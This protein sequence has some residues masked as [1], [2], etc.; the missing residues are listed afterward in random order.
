MDCGS[1]G[2][3]QK[4]ESDIRKAVSM[5][6]GMARCLSDAVSI[7][8]DC[9]LARANDMDSDPLWKRFYTVQMCSYLIAKKNLDVSEPEGD[10]VHDLIRDTWLGIRDYMENSAFGPVSNPDKWFRTIRIDFPVDP[11][12]SCCSFFRGELHLVCQN[13]TD[14]KAQT[15]TV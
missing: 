12:D 10:M 1:Q 4:T 5:S 6:I 8:C 13:D 9:F 11:F 2:G 3:K 7:L 14:K 15:K